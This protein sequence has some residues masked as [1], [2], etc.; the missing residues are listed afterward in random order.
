MN[1]LSII[2]LCYKSQSFAKQYL[3]NVQRSMQDNN[4]KSY[5]IL[6]VGN[7]VK[8]SNDKTPEIIIKLAN[9]NENVSALT[10][11]K[12]NHGW[13]GWDVRQAF[14]KTKG[15]YVALID[16][17]GQMPADDIAK[18]YLF[19]RSSAADITMTYRTTRGDG[20]YRRT[21]SYLYNLF[22]K[23]LFPSIGI[24]DI[25]SKPKVIKQELIKELNLKSNGWT[26][27][28]EIMLQA[29]KRKSYI[30]EIPTLFLGQPN[31]RKSF[32]GV[33]AIFEFIIFIISKRLFGID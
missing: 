25:N 1:D 18:C 13:L 14:A 12:P 27:D 4:I 7:Y 31:G 16:G 32:V 20:L 30:K 3:S 24:K 21:L 29:Y 33:K 22:M 6:L 23:L 5:D 8:E 9:S 17:D 19:C 26:I 28:A 2:L 10:L 11:E 15:K